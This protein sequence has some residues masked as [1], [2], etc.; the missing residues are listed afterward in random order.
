M[1]N[2]VILGASRAGKTTLSNEINKI[3]PQYH[4]FR[5]DCI[6]SSFQEVLPQNGINKYNGDGMKE[7]FAKFCAKLFYKHIASSN[8]AC[9]NYIFDTCDVSVENAKKFFEDENTI[10]VFLGYPKLTAEEAFNNF[11]KYEKETDW[12][13]KV[14]DNELR[15]SAKTWSEKSRIFE[16]DCKKYNIRFIDTSYNRDE[17]LKELVKELSEELKK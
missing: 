1:K 5:G 3:Y 14:S 7:D 9:Y 12:T 4:I 13:V 17:I 8:N 15:I 10:I 11:R 2:L 6:R 16:E